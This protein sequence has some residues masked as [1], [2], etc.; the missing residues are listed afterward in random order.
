MEQSRGTARCVE[1]LH[2][3]LDKK[4]DV[5]RV[6]EARQRRVGLDAR[7]G[8]GRVDVEGQACDW[9]AACW[10]DQELQ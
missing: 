7:V 8:V 10:R 1:A 4:T 2:L 3:T 5:Q 6:A 9:D